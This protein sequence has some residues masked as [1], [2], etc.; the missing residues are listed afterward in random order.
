MSTKF[1]SVLGTGDYKE[2]IYQLENYKESTS[3]IQTMI[4][5]YLLGNNVN[6]DNVVMLFTEDAKKKNWDDNLR[7]KF[8]SINAEV[9]EKLIPIGGNEEEI[10]QIFEIIYSS[11]EEGDEIYFDITHSLR[12]L[13]LLALIVLNYAKVSKNIKIKGIFYGAFEANKI[14]DGKSIA[15][16][17][18][19]SPYNV[20]LEWSQAV[21][22]YINFGN[23]KRLKE[24]SCNLLLPKA[25]E[26][27]QEA[28][29]VKRFV[30]SLEEF[31]DSIITNRGMYINKFKN[32]SKKSIAT[33]AG[34][35]EERLKVV[36]EN[37]NNEL[38]PLTPLFNLISNDI[39]DF[40]EKDNLTIGLA[41]T[42]WCIKNNLVPQAFTSLEETLKTY[43]C[44]KYN[45]DETDINN[46]EEIVSKAIVIAGRMQDDED[47]WIIEEENKE[48][49]SKISKGLDKEFIKICDTCKQFRNDVNHFGFNSQAK[50]SVDFIREIDNLY[51]R[52][53]DYIKDNKPVEENN[54]GTDNRNM[55]LVFSHKLSEEQKKEGSGTFNVKNYIS[56]PEELQD[57]WSNIPPKADIQDDYFTPI[58]D[59]ISKNGKENDI[60][61]VQG[62]FGAT[63]IMVNWCF[64][65]GFVPVYATT[66]RIYSSEE[67]SEGTTINHH[68]FKHIKFRRYSEE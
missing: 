46:R 16:V 7:K 30:E 33:A 22:A 68:V 48:K 62:D 34:R 59:Y 67:D 20:L 35:M 44:K 55:F 8:S 32:K 36:T 50:D 12:S 9:V 61:L 23:G 13:P 40:R 6:V 27:N 18:D 28:L 57:L 2:C 19:L 5:N 63:Y 26:K 4:Y 3:F 49:V 25:K 47:S 42:K 38:K 17:F 37:N 21:D 1:I 58:F 24:L 65:K 52:F 64:D 39:E 66:E 60:V 15:P 54:N 43:V 31:T 56:L 41:T 11:L 14:V 10:W 29:Q 45:L 51:K 53:I